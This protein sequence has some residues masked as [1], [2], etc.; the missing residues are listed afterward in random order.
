LL[1]PFIFEFIFHESSNLDIVEAS[2]R[3]F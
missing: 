2:I 1:A 3:D